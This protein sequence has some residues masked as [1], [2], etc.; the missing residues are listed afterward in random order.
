DLA[1]VV[2]PAAHVLDIAQACGKKGVRALVVISAGFKET[3]A[4]G[5]KREADL[6]ALVRS[7]GMRLIGPNCLGILN[8]DPKVSM[9]ATFAPVNPPAGR[10]A[11]PTQNRALGLAPPEYAPG[12]AL[13][14][15]Q[16]VSVGPHTD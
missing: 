8:T 14:I 4:A 7:H 10:V 12:R 6:R 11:L 9:N 16:F 1:I 2:V 15:P 3:G 5:A 13:G